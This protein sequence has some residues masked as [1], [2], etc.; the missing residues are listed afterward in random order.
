M[1]LEIDTLGTARFGATLARTINV[2]ATPQQLNTKAAELGVQMLS[3]RVNCG[4]LDRIHALEADGHR[5]MDSLIY[6][7]RSLR[8][9]IAE[10]GKKTDLTIRGATI[11]DA[12]SAAGVARMA[13][14]N[15]FGHFHSDPKL[16]TASADAAYVEWAETSFHRLSDTRPAF[17]AQLSGRT[18]GFL[19]LQRNAPEE[20]EII[21]NAVAP[22]S[23]GQGIYGQLVT[24]AIN[25]AASQVDNKEDGRILISTQ[26]NNYAVQRVW[27][28]Q[29]FHIDHGLYTFHKWYDAAAN[30]Q[31]DL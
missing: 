13:F 6:Y 28:R 16:E 26:L 20:W 29:G 10:D 23:Q 8:Q 5:L 11:E 18:V 17:I 30:P 21:L 19:T 3:T 22:D 24:A 15:Y 25:H 9:P 1:P 2:S 4:E 31:G 12:S 27:T 7:T 14:K